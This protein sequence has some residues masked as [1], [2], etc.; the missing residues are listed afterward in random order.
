MSTRQPVTHELKC[1]PEPFQAV[2][3]GSKPFEWRKDDRDYQ[4]GDTL[5][6]R[7]WDPAWRTHLDMSIGY[8]GRECSRVVTYTIREGFGIPEG[9]CIMG[10]AP[11]QGKKL[12]DQEIERSL[13]V[14][15]VMEVVEPLCLGEGT[16]KA[17]RSRLE[18]KVTKTRP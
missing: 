6:L 5:L 7:E 11:H 9:Y 8:T 4:V 14:D 10:L 18:G 2:L 16:A 15:E 17:I 3:D 1:H 13:S 12:T